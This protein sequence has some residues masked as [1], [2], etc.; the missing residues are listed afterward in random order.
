[1]QFPGGFFLFSHGK[2]WSGAGIYSETP[3][4]GIIRF[5]IQDSKSK[6]IPDKVEMQGTAQ[7]LTGVLTGLDLDWRGLLSI[8]SPQKG[9]SPSCPHASVDVNIR[10]VSR[11]PGSEM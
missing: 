11:D 6:T 4:K 5:L 9:R 2:A 7:I 8:V 1:M 10:E 3:I